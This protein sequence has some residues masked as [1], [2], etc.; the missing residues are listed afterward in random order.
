MSMK[1]KNVNENQKSTKSNNI[2]TKPAL[3]WS[4]TPSSKIVKMRR[5]PLEFK[6]KRER[7]K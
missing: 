7:E 2:Q 4:K 3:A 5:N 6:K 1:K